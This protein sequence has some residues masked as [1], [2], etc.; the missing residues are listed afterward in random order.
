MGKKKA[1]AATGQNMGR[2]ILPNPMEWNR[3]GKRT[4]KAMNRALRV[5]FWVRTFISSF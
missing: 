4:P 2:R 1:L 3:M 5:M